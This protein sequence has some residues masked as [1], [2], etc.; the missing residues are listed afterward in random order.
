MADASP[1]DNALSGLG[2]TRSRAPM[3]RR[4]EGTYR[5]HRV[6]VT[7]SQRRRSRY[8]G[9]TRMGSRYIGSVVEIIVFEEKMVTRMSIGPRFAGAEGAGKLFGRN[10]VDVGDMAYDDFVIFGKD[11]TWVREMAVGRGRSATWAM[12]GD[13]TDQ[14][15]VTLLVTPGA[16]SITSYRIAE[17]NLRPEQVLSWLDR[18]IDVANVA[19]ELPEPY[20]KAKESHYEKAV[21]EGN[22]AVVYLYAIG[23]MAGLIA[24]IA[25]PTVCCVSASI[26]LSAL[27]AS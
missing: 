2:L 14:V 21:R 10:P 16:L 22:T 7:I 9:E 13:P 27:G 17:A 18:L 3:G 20:G 1:I 12:V 15:Q 4:F 19:A 26:M 24:V 5:N 25:I 8:V 6:R 23:I 11:E